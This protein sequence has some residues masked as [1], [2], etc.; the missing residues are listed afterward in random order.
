MTDGADDSAADVRMALGDLVLASNQL[1]YEIA[2]VACGRGP[3]PEVWDCVEKALRNPGKAQE[4]CRR[5]IANVP[6]DLAER[7]EAALV[8]AADLADERNKR[9]HGFLMEVFRQDTVAVE[10]PVFFH[11]KSGKYVPADAAIVREIA[12]RVKALTV[13]MQVLSR[14]VNA[15]PRESV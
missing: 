11:P 9:V 2:R 3:D 14:E 10:P 4:A 12:S 7:V 13:E 6:S 1:E 8:K 5:R 15:V